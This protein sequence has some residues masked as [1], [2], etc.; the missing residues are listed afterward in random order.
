MNEI[1]IRLLNKWT[2]FTNLM[3]ETKAND[4]QD[5]IEIGTSKRLFFVWNQN[6]EK[7][8]AVESYIDKFEISGEFF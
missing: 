5:M 4:N 3:M 6:L 1:H 7:L 2:I 8:P